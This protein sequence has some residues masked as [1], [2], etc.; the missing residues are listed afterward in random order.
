MRKGVGPSAIGESSSPQL[1]QQSSSSAI[2]LP[3]PI[4]ESSLLGAK[5]DISMGH[6][7]CHTWWV[8]DPRK[9]S[10]VAHWELAMTLALFYV[11]LVTPVEVAFVKSPATLRARLS[12]PIFLINRLLDCMFITDMVLQFRLAY[13]EE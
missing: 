6:S 10:F 9:V 4:A 2:S 3:A 13:K 12:N 7:R 11:A 8:L 1:S 5:A